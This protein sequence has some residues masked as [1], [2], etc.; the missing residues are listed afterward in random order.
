MIKSFKD[1]KTKLLFEGERI[2]AFQSF[3]RQAEKRL[4]VLDAADAIEALQ[5]MPS[6]RFKALSGNRKGQYSIRIN[7]QWRIC[8]NWGD[9]GP[10]NV[11]IVDYH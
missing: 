9:T 8:F 7:D 6:N 11:E 2:P 5:M 3:A 4:L 10:E 1:K